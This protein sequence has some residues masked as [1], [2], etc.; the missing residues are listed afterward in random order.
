MTPTNKSRIQIATAP[1]VTPI[2]VSEF[3]L[4]ARIDHDD[5][6]AALSLM[7]EAVTDAAEQYLGRALI[8]Q[9]ITYTLDEWPGREVE[10][11]YPPLI[12]V[13][14]IFLRGSDG[15]FPVTPYAASNYF[16]VTEGIPGSI[17]LRT[18]ATAPTNADVEAA[19]YQI[20]YKAG[21]GDEATDVPAAIRQALLV[22][23][24]N[25]YENRVVTVEPP[26][27]VRSALSLY[28]VERLK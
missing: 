26:V 15:T 7:I 11:P 5:E 16:V 8:E 17:V 3:K 12:S 4:F 22:W 21:Y 24:N 23:T 10:L 19:G 20:R 28:R 9:S 6:D 13:T 25:A 27:E 14:G 1:V 18:G 2:S